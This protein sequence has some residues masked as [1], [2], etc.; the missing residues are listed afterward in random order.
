MAR[1]SAST[2]RVYIDEFNFSGYT[3]AFKMD[4]K[5]TLPEVTC[6][7]DTGA[8]FVEGLPSATAV[9]NGFFDTTDDGYDE[10]SFALIGD[11]T[12][13]YF[14]L[15]PNDAS[16][17]DPGYELQ[18][19]TD[20]QDRPVEVAGAVLLNLN[21][22]NEGAIMRTM[23]L[24]NGESTGTGAVTNSNK[25]W[26]ATGAGTVFAAVLRVISVTG[27]GSIVVEIEE[28]SDDGSGDAYS[29][30]ISFTTATAVGVE[31]KSITTATE[32]WKRVN[33][34]TFSGFSAATIMVVIGEEQGTYVAP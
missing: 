14:G 34:T 18:G 17:G 25:N 12:K 29:N 27:S 2:S 20:S 23:V 31:R 30:I 1:Q 11:G 3:N 26:G 33:I 15:Y 7:T 9:I 10:Q 19:Q 13:H 6:F 4:I 28:S 5:N 22:T 21:V 24:C 32:A 8:E 16:H